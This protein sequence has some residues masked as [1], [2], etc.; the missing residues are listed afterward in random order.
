MIL[1]G[2]FFN[3]TI[4]GPGYEGLKTPFTLGAYA[5]I[6]VE[7][8]PEGRI[9]MLA[10]IAEISYTSTG[11]GHKLDIPNLVGYNGLKSPVIYVV[12]MDDWSA[13]G[14][15]RVAAAKH[16]SI[17]ETTKYLLMNDDK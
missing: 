17:K 14:S 11:N 15:R 6:G 10:L 4:A 16:I 9:W 2:E 5:N 12:N 7:G 1:T 3:A 13:D 8:N